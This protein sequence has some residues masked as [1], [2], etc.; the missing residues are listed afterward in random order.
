MLSKL[1][2]P[3]GQRVA[4]HLADV[5][6]QFRGTGRVRPHGGAL[7]V[8][9]AAP[10]RLVGVDVADAADQA[11]V[12]QCPLDGGALAAQGLV[13]GVLVELRVQRVAGDV[14]ECLRQAFGVAGDRVLDRQSAEGALVD[15]P[16]V[17]AVGVGERQAHPQVGL[18]RC[19]GRADQELPAHAEVGEQGCLLRDRQPQVLAPAVRLAELAALQPGREVRRSRGVAPHG[20]WVQ[21]LH[22][23]DGSV[24]CPAR[25]SAPHHFHFRQLRHDLPSTEDGATQGRGGYPQ[26][27]CRAPP[28]Q[29]DRSVSSRRRR[30]CGWSARRPRPPAAPLPSCCGRC[31]CRT[32]H[33]RRGRQP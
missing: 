1:V 29:G 14:R 20:P 9:F 11:L 27:P 12:E 17:R 30:S 25:Q 28:V 26:R 18:R 31:R 10:Q 4:H 32:R 7:V 8:Q 19:R 3:A 6:D 21:D 5:P 24:R 23:L 2:P 15:E 33:H 16:Q 13:E 22:R